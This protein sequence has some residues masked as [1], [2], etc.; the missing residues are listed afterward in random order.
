MRVKDILAALRQEQAE[1]ELRLAALTEAIATFERLETA[2]R[3]PA[4]RPRDS[5]RKPATVR[6]QAAGQTF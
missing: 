1:I 3:K 2:D 5:R 4:G 6:V